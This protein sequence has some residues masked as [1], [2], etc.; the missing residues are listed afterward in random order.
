MGYNQGAP[1]VPLSPLTRL[2]S[3]VVPA[4]ICTALQ[5]KQSLNVPHT[6]L[7][8]ILPA[9]KQARVTSKISKC[10]LLNKIYENGVFRN[11]IEPPVY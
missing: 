7:K 11:I 1:A 5:M 6:T 9:H 2:F 4:Y 10:N 3:P 8:L